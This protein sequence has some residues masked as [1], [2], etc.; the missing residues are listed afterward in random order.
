MEAVCPSFSLPYLL[1]HVTVPSGKLHFSSFLHFQPRGQAKSRLRTH[2][3]QRKVSGG[4][5][6][7]IGRAFGLIQLT[8]F[9]T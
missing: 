6:S 4:L 2:Y 1:W 3:Q 7:G 9:P 8:G 5:G